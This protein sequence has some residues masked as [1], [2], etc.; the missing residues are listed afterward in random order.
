MSSGKNV[1]KDFLLEQMEDI[2]SGSGLSEIN[3]KNDRKNGV[4][5]EVSDKGYDSGS[6]LVYKQNKPSRCFASRLFVPTRP[7]VHPRKPHAWHD[8]FTI[9]LL[10]IDTVSLLFQF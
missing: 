4:S 2:N 8:I 7:S 10:Y 3:V 1:N 6:P 5:V 9:G